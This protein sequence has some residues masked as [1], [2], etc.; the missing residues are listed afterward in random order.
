LRCE[1][2]LIKTQS[3]LCRKN[4]GKAHRNDQG[5]PQQVLGLSFQKQSGFPSWS[6]G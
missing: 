6:F 4:W 3:W 1:L 2:L 5:Q